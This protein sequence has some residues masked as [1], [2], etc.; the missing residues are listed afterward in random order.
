[1]IKKRESKYTLGCDNCQAELGI[2]KDIMRNIKSYT[3]RQWPSPG[4]ELFH[5]VDLCDL[6]QNKM[7]VKQLNALHAVLCYNNPEGKEEE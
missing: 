4:K 2:A 5:T 1:M 6:C 7:T 3:F